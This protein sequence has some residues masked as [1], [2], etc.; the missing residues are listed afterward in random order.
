MRARRSLSTDR[1]IRA[2]ACRRPEY[3]AVPSWPAKQVEDSAGRA[4]RARFR[5]RGGTR[6]AE[7]RSRYGQFLRLDG[8]FEIIRIEAIEPRIAGLA[9]RIHQES[10]LRPVR[11]GQRHIVRE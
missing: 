9:L 3:C 4:G 5:C 7:S 2:P 10:E 6:L 11:A 1:C 8:V